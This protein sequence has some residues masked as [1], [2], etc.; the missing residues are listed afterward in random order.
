MID[1]HITDVPPS[2]HLLVI[3]NDD[4][5]G[6]IGRVT[7]AL[8]EAGINISNMGVGSTEEAGSAIMCIATDTE[9]DDEV[10]ERL[11]GLGGICDV[12]RVEG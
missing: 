12:K 2:P 9:V 4:R 7:S 3:K 5:P 10:I 8:G 1:D 11:R 6:A